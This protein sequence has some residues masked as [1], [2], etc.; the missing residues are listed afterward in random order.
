MPD[1]S[2]EGGEAK[3]SESV[4]SALKGTQFKNGVFTRRKRPKR[5][6]VRLKCKFTAQLFKASSLKK[7]N[8]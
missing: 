2:E 1:S 5:I 6:G 7:L 4:K 3:F 8:R